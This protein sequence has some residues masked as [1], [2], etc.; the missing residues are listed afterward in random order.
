MSITLEK[1]GKKIKLLRQKAG[2]LPED[3]AP[4]VDVPSAV[5]S[6]IESGAVQPTVAT[7]LKLAQYFDVPLEDFFSN[8]ELSRPVEVVRAEEHEK[9]E[10]KRATGQQAASY[11]F[12]SLAPNLKDKHMQ[13]F[14]IELDP[15]VKEDLQ[16]L[17]HDGEEFIYCLEG[18]IDFHA[19]KE[20][21]NLRPGDSV[22]FH[23]KIPHAL[24]GKGKS[25]S[26][27]VAVVYTASER[28]KK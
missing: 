2:V 4:I 20:V 22:Y 17:S 16:T 13:P 8:V 11:T 28:K 5:L 25:K 1:L 6:K 21:L 27:A 3:L 18:S 23:S 9:V 12:E 19:D 15:G 24:Y 7:L 26:K 14:L 10:R